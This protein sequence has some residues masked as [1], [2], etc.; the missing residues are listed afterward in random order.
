MYYWS[1]AWRILNIV[2]LE[3]P[4]GPQ[5]MDSQRVGHNWVTNNTL[6]VYEVNVSVW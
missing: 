5:S 4:G 1:L 6:L 2:L 3:E